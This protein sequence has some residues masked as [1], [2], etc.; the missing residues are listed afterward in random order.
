[1]SFT[2]GAW[3]VQYTSFQFPVFFLNLR[4]F[5]VLVSALL[6]CAF[7]FSSQRTILQTI[8]PLVF[9]LGVMS[10]YCESYLRDHRQAVTSSGLMTPSYQNSW[11]GRSRLR[12]TGWAVLKD[13][14][15]WQA[16]ALLVRIEIKDNTRK[17]KEGP[18]RGDGI[19][20]WGQGPPPLP[21]SLLGATLKI[22]IPAEGD[23]SGMFDYRQFLAG[24]A[25]Q[26]R[27]KIFD[28]KLSP[29]QFSI[30][31]IFN[32]ILSPFRDLISHALKKLLPPKEASLATAVLLGAKDKSSRASG[33][34]FS[35]LGLAH[36][37]A[38]SGLHVGVLLGLFL[39]PA[40]IL[41]IS[42]WHKWIFLW[43]ILPPYALLTG[44]PGSVVRAAGLALLA[45]STMPFG[46]MGR[47]LHLL[48]F[49][50]WITT[51]WQPDQV[52]DT[53]VRLSYVAA[54][55]ILSFNSLAK[56]IQYP[57]QGVFGFILSGIFISLSAQWFT[58][59]LAASSFGRLSLL[60]PL[61]NLIA[62]PVF[63]LAVWLIVLALALAG[64]PIGLGCSLG[65][66]AWILLRALEGLVA[67]TEV[68][69]GG[70]NLGLPVPNPGLILCWI[71][72]TVV[73]LCFLNKLA[74]GEVRR[75]IALT[76]MVLG[77]IFVLVLFSYHE[78]LPDGTSGPEV[79]QF[80]VGQG[81]GSLVR[82]PDGFIAVIDNGGRYGFSGEN[83]NGPWSRSILPWLKRNHLENPDVVILSHGHLDHT[84]G[85][86]IMLKDI[87]VKRWLVAGRAYLSL[88]PESAKTRVEF[89]IRGE[90]VH[91]WGEWSLEIKYPLQNTPSEFHEN[92]YSIVVVLQKNGRTQYLWS[93]DLEEKGE[94]L[95]LLAGGAGGKTRIWK[96]GHHGSNTS[97]SQP[98]LNSIDPDLIIISCG[99]GNGYRH[100]S[101]GY[102][103]VQGDTVPV[104][105][106][107][108]EGSVRIEFSLDGQVSWS[109]RERSGI[110][111]PNNY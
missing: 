17:M 45:T 8:W 11:P 110:L 26:W 111:Y 106:T 23:L 47:S 5:Y 104:V 15:Q 102:Y 55:G 2:L 1:M 44:L 69:T 31:N 35:D 57:R 86:A 22:T 92:D 3:L 20:V 43:L 109:S 21:G 101:H 85:S 84:G 7:G 74:L 68:T 50:F 13:N 83:I 29:A 95:L 16:P 9:I 78:R 48:G 18:Q 63:G 96:A 61:A 58:L 56:N 105:R 77:A 39:L 54:G 67:H 103:I 6:P 25:I 73:A 37:F 27:G 64:I 98:F 89:P 49:L 91:Q 34:P 94:K 71:A 33:E 52:L 32:Q 59:P 100:P 65:A 14:N 51:I 10:G 28:Y 99:V 42:P 76:A 93:G 90:I 70:F 30:F 40:K 97:G 80:D 53:G 36:L 81:D 19:L 4:L 46:R 12:T 66:L 79:W 87:Q 88:L 24:R 62:V 60:S 75:R 82:F 41:G 38:V 108:L 72:A 107:D